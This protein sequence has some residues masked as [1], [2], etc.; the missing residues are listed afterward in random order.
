MDGLPLLVPDLQQLVNDQGWALWMR[1]DLNLDLQDVLLENSGTGS[2][3]DVLR[4]Q[5]S[6]YASDHF[7]DAADDCGKNTDGIS[8]LLDCLIQKCCGELTGPLLDV[9]CSVGR[10]T[11]ELAS[12]LKTSVIGLDLNVAMLRMAHEIAVTGVARFLKRRNGTH[13]QPCEVPVESAWLGGRRKAADPAMALRQIL[14][15][16]GGGCLTVEA[17][18]PDIAW[19]VRLHDRSTMEYRTHLF[20]SFENPAD[21][22]RTEI[23]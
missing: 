4:Q 7:G 19:K 5:V 14:A 10:S 3:G 23:G 18:E 6:C 20:L 13:Y 1:R 16:I 9:G 21:L 12:R 2:A 8:S 15:D 22:M 11:F 17:E